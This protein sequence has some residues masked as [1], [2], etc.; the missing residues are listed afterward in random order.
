ML[1]EELARKFY[2][3]TQKNQ[4]PLHVVIGKYEKWAVPFKRYLPKIFFK[5]YGKLTDKTR[6]K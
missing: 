6:G 3:I 5:V 2:R 4:P 1:P